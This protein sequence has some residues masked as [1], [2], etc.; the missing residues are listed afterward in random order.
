MPVLLVLLA[1]VLFGT[2]GTARA[3]GLPATDPIVTGAVRVAVGGLLLGL[4]AL[5]PALRGS[6]RRA[7]RGPARRRRIVLLVAVGAVGVAGYQPAFFAGVGADGVAVGTLV[8]LGSAPVFTGLLAWAWAGHRPGTRWFACTGLAVVGVVLLSGLLDGSWAAVSGGGVL[9]SLAAGL[10]YAVYTLAVKALLDL[11][12]SPVASVGVVFGAA[13]L[14][15][16]AE[17][18]AVG[19]ASVGG[20]PGLAA[21]A[22]LGVMTVTVAYLLFARG[23]E[24]LPA[25]T[26][27]TL[28]LAEPVVAA[29]LGVLVLGEHLSP[30][31][32]SGAVLLVV[33]LGLLGLPRLPRLRADATAVELP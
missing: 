11:G 29:A 23:L 18:V 15:G 33:A 31:A 9:A 28:T 17:L 10:A 19:G 14:L 27:A 22:W 16:V 12:W 24:R 20:A 5:V 1:S 32:S 25:A 7:A 2:T 8:A 26:V 4:V 13:G 6:A 3:L 21:A 30:V